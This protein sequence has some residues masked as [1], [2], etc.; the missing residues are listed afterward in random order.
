MVDMDKIQS[1]LESEVEKALKSERK[2][3]SDLVAEAFK[4]VAAAIKDPESETPFEK[5][6]VE[7]K[8]K[9]KAKAVPPE[10]KETK[11]AAKPKAKAKAEEPEDDD[12]EDDSSEDSDKG[13]ES[14]YDISDVEDEEAKESEYWEDSLKE[15]KEECAERELEIPKGYKKLEIVK[16]L[17]LD[18]EEQED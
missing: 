17:I 5:D 7:S 12:D 13:S 11:P 9:A 18:D 8:P 4:T 1:V 16:L 3:V 14:A 15:L 2:R 6:E 10:V